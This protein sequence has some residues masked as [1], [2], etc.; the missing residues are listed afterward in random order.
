MC[1]G[2]SRTSKPAIVHVKDRQDPLNLGD[3]Y[4]KVQKADS[5]SSISCESCELAKNSR[6]AATTGRA[7]INRDGVTVSRSLMLHTVHSITLHAERHQRGTDEQPVH[8]QQRGGLKA[9]QCRLE[10]LGVLF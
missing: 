7:L 5:I 2:A 6:T 4:V 3:A 8:N 10:L 1:W 9:R